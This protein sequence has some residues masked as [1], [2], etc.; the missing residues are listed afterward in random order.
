MDERNTL[1]KYG[2]SG[3]AQRRA[4]ADDLLHL[5]DIADQTISITGYDRRRSHFDDGTYLILTVV[6]L[7]DLEQRVL[8]VSTSAAVVVDQVV[9]FFEENPKDTLEGIITKRQSGDDREYWL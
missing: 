9:A 1:M 5:K 8:K 4:A 6:L 2:Q 7:S 3:A